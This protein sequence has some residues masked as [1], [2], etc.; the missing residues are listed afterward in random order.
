M[1]REGSSAAQLLEHAPYGVIVADESGR[2]VYANPETER[3]FGWPCAELEGQSVDVLVPAGARGSHAARRAEYAATPRVRPMGA[4]RDIVGVRRDGTTM[5]VDI[6][7]SPMVIEERR[8]V[9]A[10]VRDDTARRENE[11]RVARLSRDLARKN[12]ELEARN[13]ELEAFAFTASHDL[14]EPLRKIV[15]F[16]D[17][18][19]KRAEGGLDETSRDYL[20]RML[21]AGRRMQ[22]LIE[23]L[24]CWS[25][26][27]TRAASATP[28]DLDALV[29][30]TLRDLEVA[31]E[32]SGGHV[33]VG[34]LGT[35]EGDPAQLRMLFQNLIGNA[36]KY[37]KPDVAPVVRVRAERLPAS[38]H[39]DEALRIE[40]S[41]NGIG[42]DPK[43]GR[44]IFELFE[45]LHGRHEYE[46]TGIGLALCRRIVERQG[47]TIAA[48]SAV[49]IGSTFVVVLP[50]RAA[51]G[52][53]ESAM[54]TR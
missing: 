9:L 26:I 14:Q 39:R 47:G 16:G 18:L 2:I 27:T 42:F 52:E 54:E 23:D 35:V 34:A 28:V 30:A 40:V 49:G 10:I 4:M 8:V 20:R 15:A 29:A 53:L 22:A 17:R 6:M 25:R 51:G 36:L 45:R 44:K 7:L 13:Q 41:D 12:T 37:R 32:R 43:Y 1:F 3:L 38:E 46:G 31:I 24:L 50:L 33:E 11:H 48:E 21:D 5:Y 19:G